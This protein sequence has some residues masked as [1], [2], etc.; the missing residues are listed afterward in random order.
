MK[1]YL[2]SIFLL[3]AILCQFN[4]S[5]QKIS[6]WRGPNRNGIYPDKNLLASWPENGPALLWVTNDLEAGYGSPVVFEDRIFVNGEVDSTSYLFSFDF[7]GKLIWKSPFGK[8]FTGSGF[9]A[10][11]P[12]NRSTPTVV[13]GL[14]YV[15]SGTGTVACF[16]AQNGKEKWSV[17]L[18][19]TFNGLLNEFGYSESILVN[20]NLLYC[21]PGGTESNIVAL[22][23]LTGKTV[24]TSPAIRDTV[25]HCSPL[26]IDLPK[27]KILV[28]SSIRSL[29]AM[30]A[31]T[32]ELLWSQK[33]DSVRFGLQGNT[34]IFSG[35]YLY[36]LAG[37]GNGLVKLKLTENGQIE[38]EV[39]RNPS[40]KNNMG[41]FV[42]V[43][44]TIF[45]TSDNKKM[46]AFD[47]GTGMLTDSLRLSSGST[48]FADG[49]LYCYTDKGEMCLLSADKGKLNL[50]S[51][52]KC[53]KGSKES[54]SHPVISD[55]ML[56]VRHGKSLMA[57]R[58]R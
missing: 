45:G 17:D 9:S 31:L 25:S 42:L 33:Q 12:G 47:A 24:W 34:P 40:F 41:G 1:K 11:F 58:I 18:I 6:Q 56:L 4:L 29:F 53:E 28:T 38:K 30:D 46:L 50:V 44:N 8:E 54:V 51:K 55:G 27:R 14:V 52:F 13:D 26:L 7:N 37:D 23:R 15:T 22:D 10:N 20:E 43:N 3:L 5:A 19:K 48:I 39:W 21:Y 16:D 49:H 2:P 35:G 32:G 36:Y 57:Y